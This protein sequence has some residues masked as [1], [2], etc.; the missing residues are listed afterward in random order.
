MGDDKRVAR[1][2]GR[3]FIERA[4]AT[5]IAAFG[6]ENVFLVGRNFE[7]VELSRVATISDRWEE[8]SA[9]GGLQTALEA[10]RDDRWI[11]VL[12]CDYPLVDPQ[13]LG[14][15]ANPA[16]RSEAEVVVPRDGE[17]LHPLAAVWRTTL[18]AYL[19]DRLNEGQRRLTSAL[20]PL[21]VEWIDTAEL[22]AEQHEFMNVNTPEDLETA[23]RIHERQRIQSHR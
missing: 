4:I 18:A 5:G 15:L 16:S 6:A 3:S 21:R 23:R 14:R 11:L 9:M 1:V 8:Q 22:T 19:A 7:D 20:E 2:G 13:T 17:R 12:A 10:C